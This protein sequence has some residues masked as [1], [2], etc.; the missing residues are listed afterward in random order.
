MGCHQNMARA[1]F[2]TDE[3]VGKFGVVV[4][5]D[6]HIDTMN[7]VLIEATSRSPI[8]AGLLWGLLAAALALGVGVVVGLFLKPLRKET[9]AE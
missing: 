4:S 6:E 2:W 1:D 9:S 3:V 7:E 8:R 5:D